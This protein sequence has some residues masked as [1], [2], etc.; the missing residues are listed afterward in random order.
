MKVIWDII[1]IK[2]VMILESFLSPFRE[3]AKTELFLELKI[4]VYF[5]GPW[6][7]SITSRVTF[8]QSS[9]KSKFHSSSTKLLRE[10]LL[11]LLPVN[12][13]GIFF[14]ISF[15]LS[16]TKLPSADFT[17]SWNKTLFHI[18]EIRINFSVT[19]CFITTFMHLIF[20]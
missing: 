18:V 10:H 7:I 14:Y 6:K 1:Q 19:E 2:G 16:Y 11:L 5:T 9:V 8:Y 4:R 17:N 12:V 3:L 13:W 15:I 20:H